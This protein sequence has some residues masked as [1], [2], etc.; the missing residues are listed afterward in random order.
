MLGDALSVPISKPRISKQKIE[1]SWGHLGIYTSIPNYRDGRPCQPKPIVT[2]SQGFQAME[3]TNF[4][5]GDTNGGV[6][7]TTRQRFSVALFRTEVII[8]TGI[9][10]LKHHNPRLTKTKHTDRSLHANLLCRRMKFPILGL[11]L[12]KEGQLGSDVT[13]TPALNSQWYNH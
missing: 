7:H 12:R 6:I 11:V 8:V 2:E 9:H 3:K 13:A 4:F 10:T 5:L 1:Q